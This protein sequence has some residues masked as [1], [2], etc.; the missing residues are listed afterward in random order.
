M[1]LPKGYGYVEFKSRVD[2]EK[3]LA[4]MDGVSELA[5][6]K[7]DAMVVVWFRRSGSTLTVGRK[8]S[9]MAA[10]FGKQVRRVGVAIV[11]AV[12]RAMLSV[13]NPDTSK[14]LHQDVEVSG[15]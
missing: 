1:N 12:R 5:K 13:S 6:R 11:V 15:P 4:H 2:A 3:A 8:E 7:G 10:V 14:K 9:R